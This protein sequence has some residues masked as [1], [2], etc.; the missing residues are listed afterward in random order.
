M[1]FA[2]KSAAHSFLP[3]NLRSRVPEDGAPALFWILAIQCNLYLPDETFAF[4][5]AIAAP[6]INFGGN[7]RIEW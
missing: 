4:P 3:A 2:H 6:E 1:E 7:V 5:L